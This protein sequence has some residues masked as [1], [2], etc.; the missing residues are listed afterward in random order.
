MKL[1]ILIVLALLTVMSYLAWLFVWSGEDRN[2]ADSKESARSEESS[3]PQAPSPPLNNPTLQA[4]KQSDQ[5]KGTGDEIARAIADTLEHLRQGSTPEEADRLLKE[6]GRKLMYA[7][8][9]ESVAAIVAFLETGEDIRTQL[10]FVV[11]PGG[12]L[13]QAPS[14]RVFLLDLLGRLDRGEALA[15]AEAVFAEKSSPD[16]WSISLRNTALAHQAQDGRLDESARGYLAL[17]F[18]E[19]ISEPA[20]ADQPTPGYLEAFDTLVY[21]NGVEY[22]AALSDLMNP[23]QPRGSQYAAFLTF[24]RLVEQ[25]PRHVLNRLNEDPSLLEERPYTRADFMARADVRDPQQREA[26]ETYLLNPALAEEERDQFMGQYP[27]Q[28]RMLSH[29]LLST[30]ISDDAEDLYAQISATLEQVQTW[31]GDARFAHLYTELQALEVHLS[32]IEAPGVASNP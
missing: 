15:A 8:R 10:R 19:M 1:R 32:E 21:I 16:E 7:P 18:V 12:V 31:Q 3:Q 24:D 29:N 6:L 17:R 23:D 9:E 13:R 5:S 20:W 22:L 28:N 14:M 4:V 30:L 11:G 26:V 25:N 27:N 2:K